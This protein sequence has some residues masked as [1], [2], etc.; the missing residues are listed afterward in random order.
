MLAFWL[1]V[2]WSSIE[3]ADEIRSGTTVTS[4]SH[5][6]GT[7]PIRMERLVPIAQCPRGDGLAV[8]GAKLEH[9][10]QVVEAVFLLNSFL[11][12]VILAVTSTHRLVEIKK[13]SSVDKEER[14]SWDR[15]CWAFSM[16]ADT[17][18]IKTVGNEL[19]ESPVFPFH[20]LED[21]LFNAE[22][23]PLKSQTNHL[24]A[25][26]RTRSSQVTGEFGN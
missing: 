1:C 14:Q 19:A 6:I 3:L 7:F 26:D 20:G 12:D 10:E 24:E 22:W 2:D 18:G 11:G 25:G 8:G 15:D 23:Q 17:V 9:L 13:I 4:E 16:R 5:A 21:G